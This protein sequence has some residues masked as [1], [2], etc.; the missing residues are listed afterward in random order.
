MLP[1][2]NIPHIGLSRDQQQLLT[3]YIMQYNQTNAAY[4]YVR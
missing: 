2:N 4:K 3:T 1:T